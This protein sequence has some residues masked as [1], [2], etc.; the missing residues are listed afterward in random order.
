MS[1]NVEEN[2][3]ETDEK[4][5]TEKILNKLGLRQSRPNTEDGSVCNPRTTS[6][7]FPPPICVSESRHVLQVVKMDSR[8]SR[9]SS[10]TNSK[11]QMVSCR[12]GEKDASW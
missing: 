6:S 12:A 9:R 7:L 10:K 8:V 11:E 1:Q 2:K 3:M 5:K 4:R